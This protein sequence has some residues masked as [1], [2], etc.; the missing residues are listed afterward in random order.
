MFQPRSLY[1]GVSGKSANRSSEE[2]ASRRTLPDR[3]CGLARPGL[4]CAAST[5]PPATASIAGPPPLYGIQ[6][7]LICASCENVSQNTR[8]AP[9]SNAPPTL[10]LCGFCLAYLPNS[11]T[12]LNG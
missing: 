3:I 1:V 12:V 4:F 8:C 11:S 5:C 10:T 9:I 6:L 7:V 2:T